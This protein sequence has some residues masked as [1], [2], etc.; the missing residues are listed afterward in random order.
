M[1]KTMEWDGHLFEVRVTFDRW[2]ANYYVYLVTH[3]ERKRFFRSTYLG[4][5]S[6]WLDDLESVDEGIMC[7]VQKI[8]KQEQN[9]LSNEKKIADFKKSC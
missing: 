5:K 7:A 3:P 9:R 2:G 8:W 6:F 1:K 4:S